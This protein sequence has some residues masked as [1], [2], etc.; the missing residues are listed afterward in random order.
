MELETLL[1]TYPTLG[2]AYKYKEGFLD[3]FTFEKSDDAIEYLNKWCDAVRQTNLT[4]MKKFVNT[5]KAHW[6][7]VITNF[8]FFIHDGGNIVILFNGFQKKSQK[9]S[10]QEIEKAINL[11][12][13]Y[14]ADRQ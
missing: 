6:E 9:T 2:E 7:G 8:T 1:L 13:Q 5:L 14:Y 10:K 4:F 3:A 11:K 12:N